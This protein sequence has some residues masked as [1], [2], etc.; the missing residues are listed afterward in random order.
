M[1]RSYAC[2]NVAVWASVK[3][4]LRVTIHLLYGLY[5]ICL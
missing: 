4:N 1:V 2:R 5:F 3:V